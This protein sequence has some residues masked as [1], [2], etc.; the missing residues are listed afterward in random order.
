MK[1]KTI[2][3]TIMMTGLLVAGTAHADLDE[4]IDQMC[5]KMKTCS[6]AQI[7]DQGLPEEMIGAM[8][9]M[10]DGM[11]KTWMTPYANT[12]GQAG[13]ENKAEACI[14]SMVSESCEKIMQSEGNFRSKECVEFEKAADAAGVDLE[15]I[16][17]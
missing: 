12:L 9:A 15:N 5:G 17:Q 1:T 6:I 16:S 3:Q 2:F 11:C 13:L 10:F 8:T 14:D 4:A 7:K